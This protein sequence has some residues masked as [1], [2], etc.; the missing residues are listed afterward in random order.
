MD[1]YWDA[2]IWV[3]LQFPELL[4]WGVGMCLAV[5]YWKR[6]PRV[7][8]I[9]LVV[10]GVYCLEGLSFPFLYRMVARWAST[11]WPGM[12]HLTLIYRALAFGQAVLN[13]GLW[14]LLLVAI[15]GRRPQSGRILGHDGQYLPSDFQISVQPQNRPAS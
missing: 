13:A 12:E 10:C 4:V 3:A 5:V 11:G 8:L 9:A 1:D 6:H 14:L 7:S 2:L 15:F